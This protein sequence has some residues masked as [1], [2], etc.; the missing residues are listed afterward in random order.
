M[1]CGREDVTKWIRKAQWV[2]AQWRRCPSRLELGRP[3]PAPSPACAQMKCSFGVRRYCMAAML[4]FE[5]KANVGDRRR[6]MGHGTI[7]LHIRR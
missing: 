2:V 5:S 1:K 6:Y 4:P 7:E 3:C